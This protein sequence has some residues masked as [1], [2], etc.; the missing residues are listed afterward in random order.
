MPNIV[1][2]PS[3]DP[4]MQPVRYNGQDYFTSQYFH[5]Q[6]QV[7]AGMQGKYRRHTHFV[8]LLRSIEAYRLYSEQG[9]IVELTWTRIKAEGN[10]LLVSL[11]PLFQAAGYN[12]LVLLN[13][14]AQVALSHHLDDALSK[15]MSVA[16]NTAIARQATRKPLDA[17]TPEELATRSMAAWLEAAKLFET[18][19]HI[20][21]QEGVKMVEASYGV[22]FRPL[23][24][25]AP[26]Q[27]AIPDDAQMLEPADLAVFLGLKDGATVNKRLA[28]L[29]W[30]RRADLGWEPT[31]LGQRH[32]ARHA[33]TSNVSGKSGYNWKWNVLAVKNALRAR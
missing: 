18:P 30:Q 17:H 33:W 12:P 4:L 11:Q 1:P 25:A 16:A 8:R 31:P 10:P 32:A 27:N 20:A 21:Q 24:K 28:D 29:G 2:L 14:T 22:N 6:Y 15:Q 5:R 9:D 23:L 19:V 7:N 26:A 13:A 3:N